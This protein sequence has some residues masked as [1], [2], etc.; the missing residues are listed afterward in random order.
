MTAVCVRIMRMRVTQCC[1]PMPVR[2][3][4]R[5]GTLMG[6]LMMRVVL[7]RVLMF[8]RFVQMFMVVLLGQMRPQ[9]EA[10]QAGCDYEFQ[11]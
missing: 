2:M 3:R 11:R 4:L 9:P 5:Y 8:D 1:V 10:H 6:V 7:M